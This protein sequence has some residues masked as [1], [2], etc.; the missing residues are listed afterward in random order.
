MCSREDLDSKVA[1]SM[2]KRMTDMQEKFELL[3][4]ELEKGVNQKLDTLLA[5]LK[6]IKKDPARVCVPVCPRGIERSM[7]V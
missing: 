1:Q 7:S 4:A 3:I 2:L 6:D 5:T